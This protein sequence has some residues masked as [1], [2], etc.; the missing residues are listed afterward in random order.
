MSATF[1]QTQTTSA[2]PS[3]GSP[4]PR[5]TAAT[6]ARE[7][8]RQQDRQRDEAALAERAGHRP[9]LDAAAD[10]DLHGD[11]QQRA[12][13]DAAR[14]RL[15]ANRQETSPA[16]ASAASGVH[17]KNPCSG[18]ASTSSA[19]GACQFIFRVTSREGPKCPLR[20]L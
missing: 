12:P 18:D 20:A 14:V 13:P 19:C 4:A 5:G 16:I 10:V 7:A 2:A 8:N 6:S 9:R 15:S 17:R 3:A 1:H 11:H